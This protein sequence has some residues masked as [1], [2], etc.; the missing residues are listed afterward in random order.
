[1]RFRLR[2]QKGASLIE[3]ALIMPLLI[4]LILGIVDA[5]WAFFQNLEVRHGAREASRL[6]AVDYGTEAQIIAETCVRMSNPGSIV[7]VNVSSTGTAIGDKVTVVV[8]RA[9]SSLTG[10][11]PFFD[12]LTLNSTVETRLEQPIPAAYPGVGGNC[13]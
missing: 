9:H 13:P 6:A 8:T 3:F 2:N 10:I 4:L 5:G 7:N 11:L 1:M 12:N